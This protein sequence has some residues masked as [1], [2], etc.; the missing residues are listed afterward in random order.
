MARYVKVRE[1]NGG[2]DAYTCWLDVTEVC[3]PGPPGPPSVLQD[4]PDPTLG[5]D[6][7]LNSHRVIGQLE[8]ETLVIDGGLL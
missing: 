4:D 1:I 8:A 5:A 3:V 2:N 6:L 7:K